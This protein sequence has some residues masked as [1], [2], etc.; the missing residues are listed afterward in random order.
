MESN[1]SGATEWPAWFEGAVIY[2][3][4]P[5]KFGE[6]GLRAVTARLD[7]LGDLGV[8]ALW[9]S[10]INAS[11]AGDFGYAV[12]DYLDLQPEVGTKVD[13]T[14]LT[15]EAHARDIRVVMD[16]V[17]NH[18]SAEHPWFL[19][20][21][22]NGPASPFYDHYDRDAAGNPT[23]YFD[24]AHLPNLNYDNPTVRR[25]MLDAFAYWV[26]ECDVDGFRVDVAWGIK[27]RAPDFWPLWGRELRAIKPDLLLL[28]EASARDP[29]Y[30]ANGF[31]AAYDWTAELGRW[32]WEEVWE[33]AS[34]NPNRVPDRLRAALTAD[35][36]GYP[37]DSLIFRFLNNN[38][39]GG[40]FVTVHGP[41]LTRVATALLLT[42]PGLPCVYTGDEIGASYQP[43][44]DRCPLRWDDDPFDLR[45]FYRTLI[46]LRH[47]LPALRSRRWTL[48]D[49]APAAGV[50]AY[51]RHAAPP[52]PPV[53]VLLQFAG[54]PA[55]ATVAIPAP[56][57]GRFGGVLA[58]ALTGDR[59]AVP[60]TAPVRVPL[61]ARGVRVLTARG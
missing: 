44:G 60:A 17:P 58:D 9:L 36:A 33:D 53:L 43:Y 50:L 7:D 11:P 22:A 34:A 25:T 37:P 56:F 42:L 13:L 14:D 29:Y 40:R 52:D 16:F 49:A 24:W 2:G 54:G 8:D 51:L 46:A 10:P 61:P 6:N 4:I 27:E 32:A 35:G 23:Y 18:T 59:F 26:R 48:L 39:T 45:L 31:D 55:E 21:Q 47:R 28:A 41:D 38:D 19:D 1:P 3:V 5:R 57:R 20:A 30:L 15:R 12:T